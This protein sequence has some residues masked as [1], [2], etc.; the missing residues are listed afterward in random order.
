MK[1]I[2]G[3]KGENYASSFLLQKG[4]FVIT[5]NLYTRYGE[6][7]IV[8]SKNEYLVFVEVKTRKSLVCGYPEDAFTFR[9]HR[10]LLKSA[11]Q[12]VQKFNYSGL[13]RVDLIAI[14]MNSFDEVEDIRHYENVT[15]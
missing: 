9:K 1:K 11:W 2:T 7:D 10:L 5:Q 15:F 13:W 3:K 6:I 12:Y 14:M 8:A 4:Y